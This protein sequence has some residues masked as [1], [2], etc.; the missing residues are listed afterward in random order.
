MLG[1][2]A[3][4]E[5]LQEYDEIV[6]K[7]FASEEEGF[8]FYNPYGLDK[9]FSVRRS[10][11]EWDAGHNEWTLR[12]FVCNREGFREEKHMK[13]ENKKRRPR[14]ISRVGCRA[15]FVIARDKNTRQ[16]YVKD[17]IDEHNHPLS[18]EDL[19]CLLRSH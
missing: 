10:Y 4:P 11:V 15:K 7:M 19:S 9:G 1:A 3:D 6:R 5:S 16:W 12:K 8:Q 17:F 13:R 2:M 14:N 18:P